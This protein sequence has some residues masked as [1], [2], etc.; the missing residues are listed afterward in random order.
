[1]GYQSFKELRVWQLAKDLVVQIYKMTAEGKFAR[2]FGFRNQIQKAGVSIAA[3]IAEGYEKNS[4]KDFIRFFYIA[5]GSLSELRTHLE[6]AQGIGYI[7]GE[8]FL[9]L[10]DQYVKV[11]SMLTKLIKARSDRRPI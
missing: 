1:M 8:A 9:H 2:D 3:N 7:T 11:G 4:D 6:I 5:K 10:D